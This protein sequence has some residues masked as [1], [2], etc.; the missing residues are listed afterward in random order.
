VPTLPFLLPWPRL[1]L[2]IRR[3]LTTQWDPVAWPTAKA[4][5]RRA[6]KLRRQLARAAR[7]N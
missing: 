4:E 3:I 1:A 2:L 5:L 6:L 7:W